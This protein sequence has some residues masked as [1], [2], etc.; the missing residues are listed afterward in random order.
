M[1]VVGDDEW[2]IEEFGDLEEFFLGASLN[3][4]AMVHEF[5]VEVLRPENIAKLS[6]LTNGLV[7]L[8]ETQSRLHRTGRA[9][10]EDDQALMK[11][12]KQL[13]IGA[14]PLAEL[15]VRRRVRTQTEEIMHPLCR[16]GDESEVIVGAR[17]R[18]V[19]RLLPRLTPGDFLTVKT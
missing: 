19:I 5:D 11:T 2:C 16:I 9:A 13:L 8:P 7:P 4:D 3:I 1:R 18:H 14:R 12:L 17:G 15:A 10:G 6:R